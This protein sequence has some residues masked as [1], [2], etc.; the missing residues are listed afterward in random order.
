M[1][2]QLIIKNRKGFREVWYE[3]QLY[4]ETERNVRRQQGLLSVHQEILLRVRKVSIGVRKGTRF[5]QIGMCRREVSSKWCG[6]GMVARGETPEVYHEV[7]ILCKAERDVRWK[8]RLRSVYQE[9]LFRVRK[10]GLTEQPAAWERHS[11]KPEEQYGPAPEERSRADA[12]DFFIQA[13]SRVLCSCR[14]DS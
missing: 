4:R 10:A 14:P 5:Q 7:K 1:R 8:R 6:T 3:K 12:R 2:R 9:V 11:R 13:A